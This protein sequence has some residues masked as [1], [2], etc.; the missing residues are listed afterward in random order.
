VSWRT[1]NVVGAGTIHCE[2]FLK[3]RVMV[4]DAGLS[5]HGDNFKTSLRSAFIFLHDER[6]F[7]QSL[8]T[9]TARRLA[10]VATSA[11]RSA[12]PLKKGACAGLEMTHRPGAH[13]FDSAL[14]R[15]VARASVGNIAW[16]SFENIV[17][18]AGTGIA[19]LNGV[20]DCP[21]PLV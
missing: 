16:F 11:G 4:S 14:K 3:L 17:G 10:R 15:F 19:E 5:T 7:D 2:R 21:L 6:A 20:H 8:A 18:I 9:T 12:H 13:A 1:R